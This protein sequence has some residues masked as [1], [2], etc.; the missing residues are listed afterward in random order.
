[1][2]SIYEF[3]NIVRNYQ[4]FNK[5]LKENKLIKSEIKCSE[6]V[7]DMKEMPGKRMW[8]CSKRASHPSGKIVR[9]SQLKGTLF[10]G[11]RASPELIMELCSCFCLK[12]TYTETAAQTGA[13]RQTI[14]TWFTTFREICLEKLR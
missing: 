10:Q 3:G 7:S 9:E 2:A 4:D 6:C 13:T 5:W 1:M 12:L 8:T 11:A 14:S